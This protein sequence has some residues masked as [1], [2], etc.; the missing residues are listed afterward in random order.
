MCL[1][2]IDGYSVN[3]CKSDHNEDK[4]KKN[5]QVPARHRSIW[6]IYFKTNDTSL[7]DI[8]MVYI[9]ILFPQ[10]VNR[11][12]ILALLKTIL[13]LGIGKRKPI[14]RSVRQNSE[15][16]RLHNHHRAENIQS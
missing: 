3:N 10:M 11:S 14:Y 9:Q 16:N 7:Q 5:C 4:H 1:D 15:I 13:A 6:E 8:G 12:N 2:C